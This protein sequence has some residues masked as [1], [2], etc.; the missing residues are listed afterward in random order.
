MSNSNLACRINFL[1]DKQRSIFED[2]K[3]C[4]GSD[5]NPEM[6]DEATV[7]RFLRAR[8]FD[9]PKACMMW[10]EYIKWRIEKQVDSVSGTLMRVDIRR[11]GIRVP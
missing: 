4:L 3:T 1:S 9:I 7:L 5:Y 2:F 11:R 6:H 8:Q 10:Q